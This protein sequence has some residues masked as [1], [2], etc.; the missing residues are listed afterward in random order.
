VIDCASRPPFASVPIAAD[1][2]LSQ[3][4]KDHR[5]NDVSN[6]V[7]DDIQAEVEIPTYTISDEALEAAADPERELR[8]S[9]YMSGGTPQFPNCC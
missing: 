6:P 7:S 9:G 3:R 1:P 8:Y 2:R 5:M 4:A